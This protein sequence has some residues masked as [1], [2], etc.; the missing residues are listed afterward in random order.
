M[1]SCGRQRRY[2]P[3]DHSAEPPVKKFCELMQT[4][5]ASSSCRNP[6]PVPAPIPASNWTTVFQNTHWI[7]NTSQQILFVNQ[8]DLVTIQNLPHD[9]MQIALN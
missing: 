5:N 3:V 8:E 2:R 9:Y 4:S 6:L 1:K 7:S